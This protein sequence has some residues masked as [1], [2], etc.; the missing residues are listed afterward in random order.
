MTYWMKRNV[1]NPT[2]KVLLTRETTCSTGYCKTSQHRSTRF[3]MILEVKHTSYQSC[4]IPLST[5]FKMLH[6]TVLLNSTVS[7]FDPW[8]I[9]D[10]VCNVQPCNSRDRTV[11]L[12]LLFCIFLHNCTILW[13]LINERKSSE[14]ANLNKGHEVAYIAHSYR[15]GMDFTYTQAQIPVGTFG[16]P[17]S[18]SLVR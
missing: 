3:P 15:Q 17:H 6:S 10:L 2:C 1:K 4:I 16:L 7:N 13:L 9:Y 12:L 11:F 14:K 5:L 18:H 8:H